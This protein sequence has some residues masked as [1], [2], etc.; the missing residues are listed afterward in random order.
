MRAGV[1]E[2]VHAMSVPGPRRPCVPRTREA[3]VLTVI[4]VRELYRLDT[5]K[6]VAVAVVAFVLYLMV[7]WV[8][9]LFGITMATGLAGLMG[10][11]G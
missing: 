10:L 7:S 3:S 11:L 2:A 6:A 9:G 5:G 1:N 8:L 4:G